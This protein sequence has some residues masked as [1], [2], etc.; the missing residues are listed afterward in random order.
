MVK[1][2]I[3]RQVEFLAAQ[4]ADGGNC[5]AIQKLC[6]TCSSQPV[7]VLVRFRWA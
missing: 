3:T 7:Q 5:S 4:N 2:V 6:W 1:S